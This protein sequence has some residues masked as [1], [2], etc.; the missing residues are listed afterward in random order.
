MNIEFIRNEYECLEETLER[1]RISTC[2]LIKFAEECF[3]TCNKYN[4]KDLEQN[5]FY[6]DSIKFLLKNSSE[7]LEL[8]DYRQVNKYLEFNENILP[9]VE[10]DYKDFV[11]YEE[12]IW[13]RSDENIAD[14][15]KKDN[16]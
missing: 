14:I 15:F 16:E 4:I 11:E 6:L 9:F 10:P 1:A 5:L 3:N 7:M 12:E 13:V 8:V 2:L